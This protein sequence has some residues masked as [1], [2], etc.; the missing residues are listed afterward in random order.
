MSD[1]EFAINLARKTEMPEQAVSFISD[2]FSA[3]ASDEVSLENFRRCRKLYMN[4][5]Q[6]FACVAPCLMR[7]SKRLSLRQETVNLLFFLFCTQE[8]HSRYASKALNDTIFYDTMKDLKYKAVECKNV[9]GV[10]GTFVPSWFGG[11]FGMTRFALGRF[12]FEV[13]RYPFRSRSFGGVTVKRFS[14]VINLHIPSSGPL[15][16]EMRDDAYRKAHQFYSY[17]FCGE[18]TVFVCLSWL[19]YRGN[20]EIF[21]EGSNLLDFMRD[22]EI[23]HS[24]SMPKF[25]DA[26]RVFGSDYKKPTA[27]LPEN[28]SLQRA[29]KQRLLDKKPT[30]MGY[31]AAVFDGE[32]LLTRK[33]TDAERSH[34]SHI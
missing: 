14:K 28:T 23:V 4:T 31:A 6:S 25:N 26:W 5:T 19:L 15:T 12:Q 32:K 27:Q 1:I 9:Y 20:S 24:V 17:I 21:P 8:L 2:C 29:F 22:F 10:Y 13:M 7:V 16:E 34:S 18:P 33:E 30:G 3:L 11:F